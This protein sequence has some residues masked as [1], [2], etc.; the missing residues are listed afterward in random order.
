MSRSCLDRRKSV[1]VLRTTNKEV[2]QL[3]L[4]WIHGHFYDPAMDLIEIVKAQLEATPNAR[5]SY[6]RPTYAEPG[7]TVSFLC[8]LW[9]LG[10]T[11]ED[12]SFQNAVMRCLLMQNRGAI[13]DSLLGRS[14]LSL[15][16]CILS[17]TG[18]TAGL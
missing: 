16:N 15:I 9:I 17:E 6:G 7:S 4:E 3:Y 12:A 10:A 18:A 2:F 13:H 5:C 8:M 1:L 14:N 11:L